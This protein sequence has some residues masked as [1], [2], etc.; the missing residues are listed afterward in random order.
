MAQCEKQQKNLPETQNWGFRGK[1]NNIPPESGLKSIFKY[2]KIANY[3][4][5]LIFGYL[6]VPQ[7]FW[8]FL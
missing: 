8:F 4:S 1:N 2:N 3:N 6:I 7:V 5:V